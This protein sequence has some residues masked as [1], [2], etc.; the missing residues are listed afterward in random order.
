[1]AVRDKEAVSFWRRMSLA[2]RAAAAFADDAPTRLK[3]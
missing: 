3:S 1:M 2:T